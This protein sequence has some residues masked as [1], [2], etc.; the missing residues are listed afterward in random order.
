MAKLFVTPIMATKAKR[1]NRA[2]AALIWLTNALFIKILLFIIFFF[3][4]LKN[5]LQDYCSTP[6]L[7]APQLS[8]SGLI[9]SIHSAPGGTNVMSFY[10]S[11]LN[12]RITCSTY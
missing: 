9:I 4:Y 2:L 12:L 8:L 5:C 7:T 11:D 10:N 1:V 6:N 3:D